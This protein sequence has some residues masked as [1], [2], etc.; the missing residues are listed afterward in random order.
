MLRRGDVRRDARGPAQAWARAQEIVR[1]DC[2]WIYL[3]FYKSFALHW[4][5]V[6]NY[7]LTDFPYGM[8]KHLYHRPSAAG[9][10]P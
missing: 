8:E 6:G 7:R 3:Y 10:A 2:P 4:N 5:T 9:T 1:E